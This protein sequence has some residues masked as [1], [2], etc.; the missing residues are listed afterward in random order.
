MCRTWIW[1]RVKGL[2]T[3]IL[4]FE[5]KCE[6]F[7]MTTC[8]VMTNNYHEQVTWSWIFDYELDCLNLQLEENFKFLI[9]ELSSWY[10]FVKKTLSMNNK[11]PYFFGSREWYTGVIWLFDL[12]RPI[13]MPHRKALNWLVRTCH[14]YTCRYSSGSFDL[15]WIATQPLHVAWF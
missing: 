12:N 6:L 4:N 3:L 5:L 1:L 11:E 9:H 7:F 14:T 10:L 2:N 8:I 13:T 15:T